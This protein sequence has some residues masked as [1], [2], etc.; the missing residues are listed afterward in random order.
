MEI[1]PGKIVTEIRQYFY[2]DNNY[3]F[4]IITRVPEC[5]KSKVQC[6]RLEQTYSVGPL[7]MNT[8]VVLRTTSSLG[9]NKTLYT[10][11]NGY[12]MLKRTYREFVNNTLARVSSD[13][14]NIVELLPNGSSG[15]TKFNNKCS[16][17]VHPTL[18]MI[19]GSLNVTTKVYHREAIEMQHRPVVMAIDQPSKPTVVL[20][21]NLHLLSFSIPGWNYSSN[22]EAHIKQL[23]KG[24][25]APAPDYDR[26]LLRIMHLFEEGEDSELSK[27]VTINIK[28]VLQG[29]GEVRA[30]EERSLTGT[31]DISTLQRWKWKTVDH[32]Q[33]QN[34]RSNTN[35]IFT[36]T[37]SPKEIRTFFGLFQQQ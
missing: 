26:I 4:S 20:P 32:L 16:S 18:W 3:A 19:V 8:E 31:W 28:E 12:Q 17:V 6:H 36:V 22:H 37:I 24:L 9:N 5:Y 11:D 21:P 25:Y 34:D 10:D 1:I 27:A 29:L 2:N 7:Q 13:T 15:K 23:D 35:E 33:T 14:F 30:L